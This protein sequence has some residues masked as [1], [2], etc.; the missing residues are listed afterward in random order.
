VGL[1]TIW[2]ELPQERIKKTVV[3]LNKHLTACVA[4]SGGSFRASAVTL[5]ISHSASSSHHQEI[6]SFQRHP[7]SI[8]ERNVQ[9][10]E[11]KK[12][13]KVGLVQ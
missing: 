1:Q 7:H 12:N 9:N 6:G 10:A 4:A 8:G 11:N 5:S 13:P 3:N 2:K